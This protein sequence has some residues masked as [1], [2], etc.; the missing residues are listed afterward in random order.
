[1]RALTGADGGRAPDA[2]DGG[3]NA[4]SFWLY[5][6]LRILFFLVP[7]GSHCTAKVRRSSSSSSSSGRPL[8]GVSYPPGGAIDEPQALYVQPSMAVYGVFMILLW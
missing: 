1:M 4:R 2:Y 7:F 8:G 5:T 6:V 3:V